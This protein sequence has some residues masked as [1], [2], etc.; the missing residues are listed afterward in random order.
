[1]RGGSGMSA[2]AA[3]GVSPMS[4]LSTEKHQRLRKVHMV[5]SAEGESSA[6]FK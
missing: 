1:M 4:G 6:R 3:A 2:A 5:N